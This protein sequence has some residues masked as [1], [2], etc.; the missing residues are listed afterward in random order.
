MKKRIISHDGVELENCFAVD[1]D[2]HL[3]IF[4]L[5][6]HSISSLHV[7]CAKQFIKEKINVTGRY[8]IVDMEAIEEVIVTKD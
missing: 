3:T 2:K 4:T 8:K 6:I 7:D 1:I 5:T